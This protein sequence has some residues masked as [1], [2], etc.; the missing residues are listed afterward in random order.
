MLISPKIL[1]ANALNEDYAVPAFNYYNLDTLMAVIKAAEA[2][3]SPVIVAMYFTHFL[4]YDK[5]AMIAAASLK[6]IE[7][8]DVP[9]ALHLDHSSNYE[10]VMRAVRCGFNSVMYDGSANPL[11]E[12]INI[13]K[14]V[15]EV[16]QALDIYTEGE[17]G[18]IMRVGAED[19]NDE[20]EITNV[21]EAVRLVK[22]TGVDSLAPAIGTAHGMYKKEPTIHFDR[23]KEIYEAV[24]VPLVMHG[25]SGIP[26]EM[27]KKSIKCGVRKI[28]VGT[29][30]KY[31]WSNTM[32]EKLN[33]GEMEPIKL[34]QSAIDAVQEV[35]K[36]KI[37][38]FGSNNRA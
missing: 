12:N 29:E 8:T 20:P 26:D 1:L 22:E 36:E 3:R 28:N 21:E 31:M 16:A 24:K 27:I 30:L 17:L 4:H 2:E 34:A 19:E 7:E 6:K 32:R 14:K 37:R 13:T 5:G 10:C 25:G 9:I 23:L 15:V 18:R 35:A 38:L 33:D 11:D